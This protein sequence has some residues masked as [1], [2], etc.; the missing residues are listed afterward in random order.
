M[1]VLILLDKLDDLIYEAKPIPMTDQ[2]RVQRDEVYGLL[3]QIRLVL[4][5]EIKQARW[6]VEERHELR[7]EGSDDD[8]LRAI[9]DSIEDLKRSQRTGP[10]PLTA[11]ASEKVRSVI[12]AAEASAAEIREEA[13]RE[14]RR[15]EADAARRGMELRKRSAAEASMRLK[16][17]DDVTKALLDEAGSASAGIEALLDRVRE[18]AAALAGALDDGSASLRRDFDRMRARMAEEA[19]ED[20]APRSRRPQETK[21][22]SQ[23]T[24]E[25]DSLEGTDEAGPSADDNGED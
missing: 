13:E 18:P 14:A 12:Q 3:D 24:E 25:W 8:P 19:G 5:E 11:A 6:I 17:A 23:A 10:P 1:D 21:V 7:A 4:P 16:R 9:A 15:I 22:T 20:E 2:V